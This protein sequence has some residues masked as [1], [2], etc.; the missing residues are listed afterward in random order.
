MQG[1]FCWLSLIRCLLDMRFADAEM[2]FAD[3]AAIDSGFA[4]RISRPRK[5]EE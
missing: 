1:F 2:R 5:I 4:V 3:A